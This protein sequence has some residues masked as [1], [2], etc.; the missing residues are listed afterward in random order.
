LSLDF[1]EGSSAFGHVSEPPVVGIV[2]AMNRGEAH[3]RLAVT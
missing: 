3:E 1:L 2:A